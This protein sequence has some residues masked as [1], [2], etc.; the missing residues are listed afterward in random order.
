MGMRRRTFL[1]SAATAVLAISPAV[2]AQQLS[3]KPVIGYL[4]LAPAEAFSRQVEDFRQGLAG[5]GFTEGSNIE[6]EYRWAG[7]DP[8]KLP[9]L[10]QELVQMKVDVISTAGGGKPMLAAAAATKTI[11]I[12][13]SSATPNIATLARV[14][15]NVTG[16]GTQTADLN[17]KRLEL[18]HTAVPEAAVIVALSDPEGFSTSERAAEVAKVMADATALLRVRLVTINASKVADF[19][20][21]FA[22]IGGS[23][24]GALLVMSSPFFFVEHPRIVAFA[25][26][27]RLPAIYEWADIPRNGGLMAYGDSVHAL[28]RRA[29]DYV[30][31]VLKGSKP[32]DLPIDVPPKIGLTINLNTAQEIGFTFPL[33][34]RD[35][36]EEVIGG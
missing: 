16:A 32:A 1:R 28:Y 2:R 3:R 29:G 24:A 34:F 14:Q 23:G 26:R 30:G 18:L 8:A 36:A 11:P 22:Q 12:V 17:P 6:I 25:N 10:A 35:R 27:S 5:Q 4:G 20:G 21:A 13:S 33:G 19:D 7:G 9:T 31:R 15:S